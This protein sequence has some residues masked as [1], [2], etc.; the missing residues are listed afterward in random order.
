MTQKTDKQA[1][2]AGGCFWCLV[3]PFE[4]IDGVKSIVS[5]FA[6]GHVEHPSYEQ[7]CTG[8][9]GHVEAVQITYDASQTDYQQLL[10]VFW[11][12]IDPTDAGGSFYDR[13]S[14]YTSAI[15]YHD[16]HQKALAEQSKQALGN[17]HRFDKPIV[18]AIQ[19][20]SNFYPAEVH[21]QNYHKK[22]PEHYNRYK[23]G[24]GRDAFVLK[25]WNK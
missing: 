18:T 5:G 9:T 2:F 11:Q 13:G 21:H 16:D 22:N 12:N 1:T 17:S 6:G 23:I 24:S 7:V 14:H 8:T 4:R 25:I 3:A 15:F 20:F 19:P 10:D